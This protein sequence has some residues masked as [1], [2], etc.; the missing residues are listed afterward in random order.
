MELICPSRLN[1]LPNK[2]KTAKNLPKTCDEIL[3]N[4]VTLVTRYSKWAEKSRSPRCNMILNYDKET[5]ILY[6]VIFSFS[7][8]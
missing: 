5:G 7:F 3:P 2:K 1:I 6:S 8:N 4:L